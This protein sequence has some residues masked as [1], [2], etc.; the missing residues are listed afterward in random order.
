MSDSANPA[1]ANTTA[2]TASAASSPMP[3]QLGGDPIVDV[4][5][6]AVESAIPIPAA[7]A[8]AAAGPA[9]R[10]TIVGMILAAIWLAHLAL[11]FVEVLG[12]AP[13]AGAV[14]L[15]GITAFYGWSSSGYDMRTTITATFV[16]MYV[17]TVAA[18]LTSA[19]EREALTTQVGEQVWEGFTWLVGAIVVSYFGASVASEAIGR[20]RVPASSAPTMDQT[21]S[22]TQ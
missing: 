8:R 17:A 21:A 19:T 16:S 3:T 1:T 18:F 6:G 10:L 4:R 11:D 14:F 13:L 9:R 5:S 2:S 22:V 7:L 15:I 12:Q 20:F